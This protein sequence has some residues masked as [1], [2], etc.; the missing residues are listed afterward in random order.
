M[1]R[2][3]VN[4]SNLKSVTHDSTSN[5]LDIEFHSGDTYRYFNVPEAEYYNLINATS[6]GKYHA[7]YIKNSYRFEK[8]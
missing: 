5:N 8:L 4:S 6:V 3:Q 1:K 7:A 2:T